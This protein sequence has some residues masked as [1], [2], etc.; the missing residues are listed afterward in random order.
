TLLDYFVYIPQSK[1]AH[2][3]AAPVNVFF[4]KRVPG[5]L[6]KLDFDFD[7]DA[8]EEE[9]SFGVGKIEDF[10]DIQM[11]DFYACVECGRCTDVCPAATTGKMLSP[12]SEERRVGKECRSQ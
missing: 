3:I 7:E 2:L 8:D 12:R 9:I 6:K 10:E 4:S 11:I 5:K 1:H